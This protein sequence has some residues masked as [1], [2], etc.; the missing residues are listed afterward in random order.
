MDF[1]S[2]VVCHACQFVIT[3]WPKASRRSFGVLIRQSFVVSSFQPTSRSECSSSPGET[4]CCGTLDT[5]ACLLVRN[6]ASRTHENVFVRPKIVSG[7]IVD[8]NLIL[9]TKDPNGGLLMVPER[10]GSNTAQSF[11]TQAMC[12]LD[13]LY[14]A[15]LRLTG[16]PSDAEDLVQDTC[17]RAYDKWHQYR[18][19][20]NCRAWMLRILTN[21]FINAYRR[22]VK[23]RCG[24]E[25]TS[26]RY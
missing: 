6:G 26:A 17:L 14:G 23:E 21:T 24:A 15:A 20:T 2:R 18:E 7:T 22:R 3:G 25:I 10:N 11:N 8:M 16:N 19:G 1:L 9:E 4:S 13:A 5:G 12:H